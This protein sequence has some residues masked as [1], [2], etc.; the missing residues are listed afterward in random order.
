MKRPRIA[1]A[2]LALI[3]GMMTAS[4][5]ILTTEEQELAEAR[6]RWAAA[7]LTHYEFHYRRACFCGPD[8]TAEM[9]IEVENGAI[10]AARYA[11]TGDAVAPDR[12]GSFDSIEGMF[13]VIE[14]AIARDADE[15]N[16]TYDAEHGY[17]VSIDIDYIHNAVDDELSLY[18]SGL[19]PL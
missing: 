10:V 1:F 13:D 14:D 18:A 4:C 16:V 2:T 15:L 3:I 6:D 5:T 11:E 12:F 9:I 7:G 19:R 8:A 17:P